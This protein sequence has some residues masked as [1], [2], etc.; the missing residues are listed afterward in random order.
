MPIRQGFARPGSGEGRCKDDRPGPPGRNAAA[1]VAGPGRLCHKASAVASC[2]LRWPVE[3]ASE[4]DRA[5][6]ANVDAMR[7][8][9]G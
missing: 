7:K 2:R 6:H 4:P 9:E 8:S 1:V 5:A 3:A